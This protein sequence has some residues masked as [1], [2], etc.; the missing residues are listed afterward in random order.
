MLQLE[1]HTNAILLIVVI[2]FLIIAIMVC[3][4]DWPYIQTMV[5]VAVIALVGELAT[6]FAFRILGINLVKQEKSSTED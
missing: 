4:L 5:V 2:V 6:Y 3:F 1:K